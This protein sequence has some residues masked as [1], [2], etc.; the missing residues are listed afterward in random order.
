MQAD[1]YSPMNPT[2]RTFLM[3]AAALAAGACSTSRRLAV[4]TGDWAAGSPPRPAAGPALRQMLAAGETTGML[5]IHEGRAIF[6]YG[7]IREVTYLASARKSL[8]S[9]VYG[10]A[11]SRGEID[12]DATLESLGFD[13]DGGLMPRERT[14]RIRDL[15]TA[16]SG[17]YHPAANLGD[18]S[19]R[20]PPRG[21]VAPGSYF[22]YNNWDF[23]A[24]GAI[25]A[26]LTG[27][28]LYAG[29]EADLARPLGLADWKRDERAIRN[30]TGKSRHPAH[31]FVLSTRDMARL[32]LLMLAGGEWGSARV[33]DAAWVRQTTRIVTSAAEVARTS[34]FVAGLGYG[35]LWWIFDPAGGWPRGIAGGYTATGAFG[36]FITILPA[37]DLVV[38]H[39]VAA[40]SSRNVPAEK[41][42]R[43]ILPAA[44]ALVTT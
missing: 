43:E 25:Y 42:L 38:A 11:V 39:K 40:P 28:D 41:Y 6:D 1:I 12:L 21:S 17:V 33:I 26:Q 36:Q 3:S 20:A 9:M 27:R 18:A 35:W 23:N 19:D 22:L 30:D 5:V 32:G 2:R 37:L 4:P 13:D 8:V 31:H 7:D 29:F 14:A 15:L 24:L 34:P 16:R 10:P 44:A